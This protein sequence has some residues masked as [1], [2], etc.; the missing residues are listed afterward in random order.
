M[1]IDIYLFLHFDLVIR[2]FRTCSQYFYFFQADK[3]VLNLERQLFVTI[4]KCAT[5]E[6]N[7]SLSHVTVLVLIILSFQ[8]QKLLCKQDVKIV[9][10]I[11]VSRSKFLVNFQKYQRCQLTSTTF[12]ALQNASRMVVWQK[13]DARRD[14]ASEPESSDKSHE[15][16]RQRKRKNGAT[17]EKSYC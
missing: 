11:I 17:R 5:K 3:L 8:A 14:A 7:D 16:F 9:L 10:H 15:R 12:L 13:E 6:H 4:D 1:E 2:Y